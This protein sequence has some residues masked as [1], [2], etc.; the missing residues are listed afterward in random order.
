MMGG[1]MMGGMGG[2]G[3]GAPPPVEPVRS[4]VPFIQCGACKALVRRAFFVGKQAREALKTRPPTEEE[5]LTKLEGIC[6]TEDGK[7]GEWIHGFDMVEKSASRLEHNAGPKRLASPPNT[8]SPP[9]CCSCSRLPPD[10]VRGGSGR[11]I[12]LKRMPQAGECGVE[13]KTIGLACA[14]V[15]AE[16]EP[17][18]A[19]ALYKN[20]KTS[21]ELEALACGAAGKPGWIGAL[22]ARPLPHIYYLH[23]HLHLHLPGTVPAPA[24]PVH[25]RTPMPTISCSLVSPPRLTRASAPSRRRRRPRSARRARRSRR[26]GGHR[27][28]SRRP[29]PRRRRRRARR[30]ARPR[31]RTRCRRGASETRQAFQNFSSIFYQPAYSHSNSPHTFARPGHP[32]P[33]PPLTHHDP[34][35]QGRLA[36]CNARPTFVHGPWNVAIWPRR[37]TIGRA[38]HVADFHIL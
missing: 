13:C 20:E 14:N 7:G 16:A 12:D 37:A 36:G 25:S 27:R 3:G 2:M 23:L 19:E 28:R 4:D 31:A 29:R 6:D 22:E 1:G 24:A 32:G 11:A 9:A 38:A 17:D 15:M 18:L 26:S 33:A 5:M 35:I 8:G 10:C 34:R 21:K 30:V